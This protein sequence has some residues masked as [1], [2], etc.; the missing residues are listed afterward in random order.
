MK[1]WDSI[2]NL[3]ERG[4]WREGEREYYLSVMVLFRST[5]ILHINSLNKKLNDL[6][7]FAKSVMGHYSGKSYL[8]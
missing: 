3:V 1:E 8:I 6:V 7:S 2:N 4:G 5:K